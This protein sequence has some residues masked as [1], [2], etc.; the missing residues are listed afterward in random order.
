MTV[1]SIKKY[2]HS[3]T[4]LKIPLRVAFSCKNEQTT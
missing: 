2:S 4:Y 1:A 3:K